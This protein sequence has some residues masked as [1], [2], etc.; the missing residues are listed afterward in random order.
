MR[1]VR[2]LSEFGYDVCWWL[3]N[4]LEIFLKKHLTPTDGS[5]EYASLAKA[6]RLGQ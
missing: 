5:V 2:E 1:R 3:F 6:E 4:R